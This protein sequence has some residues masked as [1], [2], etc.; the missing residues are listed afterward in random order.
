MANGT[1]YIRQAT[2]KHTIQHVESILHSLRGMERVLVDTDDGEVKIEYNADITTKEEIV[3]L[4]KKNNFD[5]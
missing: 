5:V 4:L 3:D 1:V 2:D